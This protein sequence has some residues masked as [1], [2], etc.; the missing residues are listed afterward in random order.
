MA[1]H[2][3]VMAGFGGQGLM[4]IGKLLAKAAMCEGRHV[5][6][7]PSYGPEMRG[8]TANCVV[9]VDDA[10][11]GSP[12]VQHAQAALVMNRPSFDKFAPLLAPGGTIVVNGSLVDDLPV[13]SDVRVVRIAAN[14]LAA[15]AGS[16]KAANMAMLGAYLA[17]CP[18][19]RHDTVRDH[20]AAAFAG[21]NSAVGE[22]N[23]RAFEAGLAAATRAT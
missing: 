14:D 13:R 5:T 21:K 8:G 18:V 19:V 17:H 15:R 2:D 10:P 9:V 22:A 16:A 20:I 4:A 12:F 1:Q 11:I 6:W 3:V 23:V 7:L